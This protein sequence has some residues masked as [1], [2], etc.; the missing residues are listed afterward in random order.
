LLSPLQHLTKLALRGD[1]YDS[2]IDFSDSERY[3]VDTFATPDDLGYSHFADVPFEENTPLFNEKAGEPYWE[4][5]HQRKMRAEAEK[6]ISVF[7]GLEWIY[8]G[9]RAMR[10]ALD[11][12]TVGTKRIVSIA[13]VDSTWSYFNHMFGRG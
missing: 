7:P 9:E 5:R 4:K 13:K 8:L 1:T 3:Y 6:Y 12:D 10:I 11:D 2:G